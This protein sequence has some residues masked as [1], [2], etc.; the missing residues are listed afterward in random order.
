MFGLFYL[1]VLRIVGWFALCFVCNR[2]SRG[3]L[4]G[5]VA[6]GLIGVVGYFEFVF[7]G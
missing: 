2:F 1:W 3:W 7:F 4:T 5:L 6:F